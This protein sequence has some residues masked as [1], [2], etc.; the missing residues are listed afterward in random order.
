MTREVLALLLLW[1][2]NFPRILIGC[3]A[4]T[5]KYPMVTW[6]REY[7]GEGI[8]D[9]RALCEQFLNF[10]MVIGIDTR[11]SKVIE[12]NYYCPLESCLH[13]IQYDLH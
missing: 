7:S 11:F 5:T 6:K 9:N 3:A 10:C 8:Q 13:G 1:L 12:A 4:M 2:T